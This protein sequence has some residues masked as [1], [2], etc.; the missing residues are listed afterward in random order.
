MA[1]RQIFENYVSS[2]MNYTGKRM[3][4]IAGKQRR[5]LASFGPHLPADR[6]AK[7]LDLGPGKGEFLE[8]L[9]DLGYQQIHALDL[10]PEVVDYCNQLIPG[11]TTLTEN[12]TAFF[13]SQRGQYDLVSAAHVLEH[14]PKD[15][16]I[17][18]LEAIRGALRPG[19]K[20]L[21]EVPNGDA[22]LANITRYG[23]FTHE[24]AFSERS[25]RQVMAI[26]GFSS[27]IVHGVIMPLDHPLRPLQILGQQTIYALIKILCRVLDTYTP[28]HL[29]TSIVCVAR[30]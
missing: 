15:E 9:R 7:I 11:S 24:I 20:L 19:G 28:N 14:V 2:Q 3:R 6:Q 4:S 22:P 17:A 5:F 1:R 18:L 23:D 13:Q 25:L 12:P 21:I 10:S 30:Q 16:L 27:V 8:L 29:Q 26:A